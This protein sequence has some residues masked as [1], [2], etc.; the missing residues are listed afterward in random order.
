[1][2]QVDGFSK[3]QRAL[4]DIM[5]GLETEEEVQSFIEGLPKAQ[6]QDAETVLSMLTW[7]MI[8]TFE[9]VDPVIK[10]ELDKIFHSKD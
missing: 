3:Q 10:Q 2:I 4:A 6:Q 7:A 5:W 8:D 9:Q 1:M